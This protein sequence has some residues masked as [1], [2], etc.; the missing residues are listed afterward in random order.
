MLGFVSS[1]SLLTA[2]LFHSLDDL[3]GQS[4]LNLVLRLFLK[5]HL[6]PS[7]IKTE[8]RFFFSQN[9][10]CWSDIMY[11]FLGHCLVCRP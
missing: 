10:G 7:S 3:C 9:G 5:N 8:K 1:G 11:L 4:E 6:F 2:S